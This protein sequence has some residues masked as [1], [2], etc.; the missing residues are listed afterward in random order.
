MFQQFNQMVDQYTIVFKV[1]AVRIECHVT[2]ERNEFE[3]FGNG[4]DLS[5]V[6]YRSDF[7]EAGRNEPTCRQI[8]TTIQIQEYLL[9]WEWSKEPPHTW[10]ESKQP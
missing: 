9:E 5:R 7:I 3:L 1:L 8:R 6:Q 2:I 4:T 10:N